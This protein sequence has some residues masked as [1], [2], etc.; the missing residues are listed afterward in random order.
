MSDEMLH[1]MPI[2]EIEK[3]R[4]EILAELVM[5]QS[6]AAWIASASSWS[7]YAM[8]SSGYGR[9]ASHRLATRADMPFRRRTTF[10]RSGLCKAVS[11]PPRPA[12]AG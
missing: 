2:N 8:T 10:G 5:L 7:R 9:R 3:T 11:S 1:A 12:N 6:E 4:V